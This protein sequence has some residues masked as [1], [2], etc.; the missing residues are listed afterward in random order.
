[1]KFS[2]SNLAWGNTPLDQV[3]P[4]LANTGLHGVEIAP[5]AIWSDL[6]NLKDEEVLE[7][8]EYLASH[9]LF[10]SG[11]QSL[12]YGHPKLQLFNQN[13]WEDLR[14]HLEK[15]LKIGKIL[16]TEI[17]V[18]GSP[19]N[20]VRGQLDLNRADDLA[21]TFLKQLI[22]SLSEYHM[23]LTLEPNAPQYG[24]DY[25]I[26]YEDAIRLSRRI[27]SESIRPQVDT[28]CLWMIDKSPVQ[29]CELFTP[30]HVHL[31]TPD[32]GPFPG[33]YDFDPLFDVLRKSEYSGWMVIEM[34]HSE[35]I[36]LEDLENAINWLV[37]HAGSNNNEVRIEH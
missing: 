1:L 35:S 10:V 7:F 12:L 37:T 9:N 21:E 36:S 20:R 8:K 25:L 22:P 4:K 3:I 29:A 5:T 13:C 14:N 24:A 28:G 16:G 2:I 27:N 33:S 18:F 30:H 32:L 26:T 11:I 15:V 17:A 6:D 19:K 23:V 34:L 31:S